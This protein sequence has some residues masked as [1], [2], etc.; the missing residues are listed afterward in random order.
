MDELE[1]LR[2]KKLEELSATESHEETIAEQIE[3]AAGIVKSKLTKKALERLGNIKV[4][5]PE[6]Y[7][8]VI[9]MLSHLIQSGKA[10]EINDEQLK[11]L[12]KTISPKKEIK[13]KWQ[14]TST[15]AES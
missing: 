6:L 14:G 3:A 13:L 12:L 4:A 2:R 10:G 15:S 8:Q 1:E 5:H 9:A 11:G 7:F